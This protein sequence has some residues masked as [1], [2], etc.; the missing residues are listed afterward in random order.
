MT[1]IVTPD[2]N[3]HTALTDTH[4]YTDARAHTHIAGPTVD[5]AHG[6]EEMGEVC[7]A[8]SQRLCRHI[9]HFSLSIAIS[10]SLSPYL[11]PTPP[12][13]IFS[14]SPSLLP[15]F[16]PLS[17]LCVAPSPL[18]LSRRLQAEL[19]HISKSTYLR[20]KDDPS[21]TFQ[22]RGKVLVH[23]V[24][25]RCATVCVRCVDGVHARGASWVHIA[26]IARE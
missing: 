26:F 9:S 8:G 4:T 12:L 18:S 16:F 17:W 15:P 25:V 21:L 11:S 10:I 22:E 19:I 2:T 1:H 7:V 23:G 3:A 5:L 13:S 6:M 20:S 24:C 14:L